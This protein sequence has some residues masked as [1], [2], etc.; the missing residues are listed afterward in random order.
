MQGSVFST[1]ALIALLSVTSCSLF[2]QEEAIPAYLYIEPLTL[3]TNAGQGSNSTKITE[4]WVS[5]DGDFLGAYSLP[6]LLPVLEVGD[7]EVV[8]N[9]G[10]KDNGIASFPE[11]YPFYA[12]YS[13][14][15]DLQPNEVDTLR[16]VINYLNSA[17]FSMIEPFE[18]SSHYFQFVER[19]PAIQLVSE[20]AFEGNSAKI[21]LD[22]DN[23]EV[24][25]ATSTAFASL[26]D[27]D[28]RV[29]LEVNYRSDVPVVMGLSGLYQGES[30][31]GIP[32][33][34]AGFS[35]KSNWNKIYFNL[36]D[37]TA[38]ED[39]DLYRV[40]LYSEIPKEGGNFTLEEADIWLDNIKLV[41]F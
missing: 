39:Y 38:R 13:R 14:T 36:T 28:L 25:I 17:V 37:I 12:P 9:A 4:V 15:I 34:L 20:G 31:F 29:Y 21:H 18:V 35:E 40:I 1:M 32:T 27:K 7:Q 5:V 3:Q 33:Y 26:T 19:G 16:P 11:I 30:G 8:L 41:H 22:T 23:S 24:Q 6:A 2:D 10:I